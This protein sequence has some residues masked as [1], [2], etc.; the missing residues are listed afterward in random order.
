M[1]Q[2]IEQAL[3]RAVE[4]AVAAG[5]LPEGAE[6]PPVLLEEPPEKELGD[7]ATNFAMQS[8]RVFRQSPQKIAAAI[9][10]HLT[11][12]WLDHAEVAGPGFLNLYLKKAVIAD[13]L[14]A[15]LAAGE[16]YGTLPPK[17]APRIQVE[18]VSANPTGPLHV[19]HA[20]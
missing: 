5:Q 15:V 16:A 4:A 7:F 19:G 12:D 1:K 14:R 11:G 20:P 2:Q 17:D 8:A 6:L 3:V 10:E 9:R 13:T 18:Y